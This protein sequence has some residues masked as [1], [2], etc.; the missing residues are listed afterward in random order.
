MA[1]VL[2][3]TLQTEKEEH[4]LET[5]LLKAAHVFGSE[6]GVIIGFKPESEEIHHAWQLQHHQISSINPSDLE[7][8]SL[9][10]MI[11]A[12]TPI[13][14]DWQ[15]NNSISVKLDE[16]W[17][18]I[19]L[20]QPPVSA[21]YIPILAGDE[22]LGLLCLSSRNPGLFPPGML[23]WLNFLSRQ[24]GLCLQY[25]RLKW[26]HNRHHE[27]VALSELIVI[28][29]HSLAPMELMELVLTRLQA[30]LNIESG[31][32]YLR[33]DKQPGYA[34]AIQ[35][36]MPASLLELGEISHAQFQKRIFNSDHPVIVNDL[37]QSAHI[38]DILN[39]SGYR[40]FIGLPVKSPKQN[41]GMLILL[42]KLRLDE[43][44]SSIEKKLLYAIGN[45]MGSALETSHLFNLLVQAKRE[46]ENTFDSIDDLVAILD[47]NYRIVR[48]NKALAAK[49]NQHPRDIIG[50]FCYRQFD[51]RSAPCETCPHVQAMATGKPHSCE[52]I[53]DILKGTY[54]VTAS[55]MHQG[56]G[57]IAATAYVARDITQQ[58]EMFH[59]L[60]QMQKMESVGNLAGGIAHDFNNLLDGIL[61]YASYIKESMSPDDPLYVEVEAIEKVGRRGAE[62]THQLLAFAR[63]Q[64]AKWEKVNLNDLVYEITGMLART[65]PKNIKIQKQLTAEIRLVEADSGQLQQAILNICINARDAM[66]QGGHLTIHSQNITLDE[67]FV[68]RNPWAAAGEYVLLSISDTGQGIDKTIKDK[69]FEPF[70]TTK[71][72][73]KN[74]GMGLAMVYTIVKKHKGYI[75]FESA[76]GQGTIFHI[77]LPVYKPRLSQQ[78]APHETI[79]LIDD[80]ENACRLTQNVLKSNGYKV[81]VAHDGREA[82]DILKETHQNVDLVILDTSKPS[83]D[84]EKTCRLL[85][86]IR[87]DIRVLLSSGCELNEET[88][89]GDTTGP[90]QANEL[91]ARVKSALQHKGE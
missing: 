45:G 59:H 67:A 47:H 1:S 17:L 63:G 9:Y 57:D 80:E 66:P 11:H 29:E 5:I 7:H 26:Q 69:V 36:G 35:Q 62:L 42:S 78:P 50:N 88:K 28:L 53:S 79:L 44:L 56:E 70:F 39:S 31:G 58:K 16:R 72:E 3:T 61:G 6:T 22:V 84:G 71:P 89:T 27:L 10:K 74:T 85:K 64:K 51:N 43:P 25:I 55:P 82:V 23:P 34:L 91:M 48:A 87:S 18:G 21:A 60:Q 32:V 81:L 33:G 86:K 19:K 37:T 24:L 13:I 15:K 38:D 68:V 75:H 20:D 8:K 76:P 12:R 73:G 49:F 54:L 30:I 41:W 2:Q 4:S 83:M 40:G 14:H 52:K 90:Y 65:I 46:W 77:Y